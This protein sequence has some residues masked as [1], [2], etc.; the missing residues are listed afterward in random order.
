[1]TE[2]VATKADTIQVWLERPEIV[3]KIAKVA[4]G[5]SDPNLL[6]ANALTCIRDNPKLAECDYLSILAALRDA[7]A[8]GLKVGVQSVAQA[9]L[10]PYA[11]KC[12]LIPSYMGLTQLAYN[13]GLVAGVRSREVRNGDEFYYQYGTDPKIHH[14]P[15]PGNKGKVTHFYADADMVSGSIIFEVMTQEEVNEIRDASPSSK[16]AD[17]PWKKHP[18]PMG[19]KCP[20]RRLCKML[21]RNNEIDVALQADDRAAAWMDRVANAP[22]TIGAA[23][24]TKQLTDSLNQPGEGRI[25]ADREETTE[26]A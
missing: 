13:S 7:A 24:L 14:V 17:S 18:I 8:C 9:Y 4:C 12:Q 19:R 20:V 23:E 25:D 11:G 6:V 26:D 22:P 21:P 16:R 1:M 15:I 2:L 10:V 3:A 5:R